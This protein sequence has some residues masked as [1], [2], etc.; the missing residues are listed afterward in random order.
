MYIYQNGKLYVQKEEFLIGVEIYP[1]KVLEIEGTETE[2]AEKYDVCTTH[3]VRCRFHI[4]EIPYI[5]PRGEVLSDESVV[6][7]EKPTRKYT[8]K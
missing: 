3:E 2:L 7:T 1:D 5:F 8:R 6:K 4:E